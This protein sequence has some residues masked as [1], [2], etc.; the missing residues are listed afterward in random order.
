MRQDGEKGLQE[1]PTPEPPSFLQEAASAS[2]GS[3]SGRKSRRGAELLASASGS[4]IGRKSRRGA[5]LPASASCVLSLDCMSC[6]GAGLSASTSSSPDPVK[7]AAKHAGG[8]G[9]PR[10]SPSPVAHTAVAAS[11][12]PKIAATVTQRRFRARAASGFV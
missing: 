8:A 1:Q 9:R 3:S 6:C 4:S 7:V 11:R 2:C 10:L 12:N 5:E